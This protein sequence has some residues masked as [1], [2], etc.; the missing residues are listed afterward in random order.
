MLRPLIE[1][2]IDEVN[3][4]TSNLN[5]MLGNERL[6]QNFSSGIQK[7]FDSICRK[8]EISIYSAF[9]KLI[10]FFFTEKFSMN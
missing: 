10:P 3:G 5:L 1:G 6:V 4:Q 9:M 2:N 7:R 8:R